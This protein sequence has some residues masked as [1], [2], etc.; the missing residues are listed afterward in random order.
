VKP[1]G[2]ASTGG[3]DTYRFMPGLTVHN[4]GQVVPILDPEGRRTGYAFQLARLTYQN[5]R[6][7]IL[8]LGLIDEATGATLVYS[9]AEPGAERIG[10]NVRWAQ[11]GL[12]RKPGVP[13]FAVDPPPLPAD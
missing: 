12:T 3:D 13:S 5:T 9:W 8:K 10:I 11:V 1:E 6:T 7:P 4:E 2:P